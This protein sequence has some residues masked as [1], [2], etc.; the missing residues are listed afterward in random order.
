MLEP[1]PSLGS[2]LSTRST[3]V[4]FNRTTVTLF[5]PSS[6]GGAKFSGY[7]LKLNLVRMHVKCLQHVSV[8]LLHSTVS[9]SYFHPT[10]GAILEAL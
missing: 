8:S 3:Q 7:I 5:H 10:V 9:P 1:F 4:H 2:V 6:A